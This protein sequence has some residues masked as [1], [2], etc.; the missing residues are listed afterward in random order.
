MKCPR[1]GSDYYSKNGF[2]KQKQKYICKDCGR[3]WLGQQSDRGYPAP[4]RELC[5]KMYGNGLTAKAI[6][7]YTGI[8]YNTI[9]NWIK[10]AK[11][12]G[13][14]GLQ[15]VDD[16]ESTEAD[17]PRHFITSLYRQTFSPSRSAPPS[18]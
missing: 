11:S 17:Q 12:T 5:M 3:Q 14:F 6:G 16:P 15:A 4:V 13:E 1:C 18:R 8:S 9:I 10:Q 2:H 7:Q